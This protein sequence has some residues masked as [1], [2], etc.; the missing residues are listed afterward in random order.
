MPLNAP[1]PLQEILFFE[2]ANTAHREGAL[3][4]H[5]WPAVE[6]MYLCRLRGIEVITL[7]DDAELPNGLMT[8]RRKG[9]RDNIVE[10]YARRET[11]SQWSQI[12]TDARRL[13]LRCTR[14]WNV[15]EDLNFTVIFTGVAQCGRCDSRNPLV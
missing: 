9:S 11:A 5:L 6:R 7:A 1:L 8:N 2:R 15:R 4:A 12:T 14:R 10:G 13:R 3:V